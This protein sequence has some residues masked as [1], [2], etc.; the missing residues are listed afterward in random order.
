M[1]KNYSPENF[2]NVL[3]K[4]NSTIIGIGAMAKD[5]PLVLS[6][7]GEFKKNNPDKQ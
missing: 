2:L 4:A 6:A 7:A 1:G 5:L 3:N